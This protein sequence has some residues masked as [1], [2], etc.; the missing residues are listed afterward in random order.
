[1]LINLRKPC[2][3]D[4]ERPRVKMIDVQ[5]KYLHAEEEQYKNYLEKLTRIWAAK[6]V[7]YKVHARGGL[8]FKE[9]MHITFENGQSLCQG[10]LKTNGHETKHPILIEEVMGYRLAYSF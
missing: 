7:L 1:A 5:H 9:H 6:E 8:S 10:H 4:L 2:G 3:V